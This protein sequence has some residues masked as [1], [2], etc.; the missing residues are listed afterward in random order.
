MSAKIHTQASNRANKANKQGRKGKASLRGDNSGHDDRKV[1]FKSVLDNPLTL[2]WPHIPLNVQNNLLAALIEL[3]AQSGI[4]SF[5][6]RRERASRKK[7]AKKFVDSSTSHSTPPIS[8]PASVAGKRKAPD[9]DTDQSTSLLKKRKLVNGDAAAVTLQPQDTPIPPPEL[10]SHFTFGINQVTKRLE[11]QTLAHRLS[12]PSLSPSVIKA[13]DLSPI[14]LVF[15]CRHDVDPPSLHAHLPMLV[16]ACNSSRRSSS[17]SPSHPDSDQTTQKDPD[18]LL[19]TLPKGAE[20]VLSESVALRRTAVLALDVCHLSHYLLFP[21]TSSYPFILCTIIIHHHVF[22]G[23]NTKHLATPFI[24]F[25]GSD[26][27][28]PV[29]YSSTSP[30][31]CLISFRGSPFHHRRTPNTVPTILPPLTRSNAH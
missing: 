17:A 29:A 15:V 30:N 10:L 13:K 19:I 18:I 8:E 2:N 27:S 9:V 23:I 25:L 4:S 16:A 12:Q 28:G 26:P 24:S 21:R 14:H 6:H 1:V 11:A 20:H 3:I 22:P 31:C 5:H 7:K